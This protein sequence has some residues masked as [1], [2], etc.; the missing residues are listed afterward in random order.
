MKE[1]IRLAEKSLKDN[2]FIVRVFDNKEEAKK[3]LLDSISTDESVAFGGSM[4]LHEM[5]LYDDFKKRGY[6]VFWHWKAEDKRKELESAYNAD[7]YLT[8]TNALTLDGKLVN[9]DGTANRV[10]SMFY[11]HER[12]YIIAGRNKIC[13]D[14]ED[15]R[16]R[17]KNVAAPKNAK[18]LN[19]NTP[20][21]FTGKC[22]DCD[23]PDRICSVEV[24]L[25]R[26]PTGANINV[27]IIDE[28]LGY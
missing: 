24:I 5:D 13:K 15:A 4:T 23:S 27:Y 19:I 6:K 25:H 1:K 12:V 26:N 8:S 9:M 11:G 14:Y 7:I 18:R 10:S 21:R 2:G 22:N 17:I 20:C 28:D 3:A 16:E